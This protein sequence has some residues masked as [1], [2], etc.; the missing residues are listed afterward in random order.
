MTF[1]LNRVFAGLPIHPRAMRI[2]HLYFVLALAVFSVFV[3]VVPLPPLDFWWHLRVGRL[4]YET[5]HIPQSNLFAWSVPA[6][7]P[8][9]YAAWLGEWLFFR[10]YQVGGLELIIF[11]RNLLLLASFVVVGV[12]AHDRTGSWRL[13]ATAVAL[14]EAMTMN[15]VIVRTQNW[16]WLPFAVFLLTLERWSTGIWGRKALWLLPGIMIFWVNVHGAFVL[17]LVIVGVYLGA[18]LIDR[19]RIQPTESQRHDVLYL[20]YVSLATL[21][22]TF[23]NPWGV[24]IIAYVR[25]LLGNQAVQKLVVEWQPPTP[26]GVSNSI[27]FVSILALVLA[28]ANRR[29]NIATADQLLV[30]VFLW[31][32]WSGVRNVMWYGMVVMPIMLACWGKRSSQQ[33]R[34]NVPA[35]APFNLLL[36]AAICIPVLLIQPWFARGLSL[37][38]SYNELVLPRPAGPYVS[39]QTPDQAVVQWLRE[40]PGGRLFNEMGYGSFLIWALPD[41]QVFIDPRIELFPNAIWQD[42]VAIGKGYNTAALLDKYSIDRVLLDRA[43]QPQLAA[44]LAETDGWRRAFDNPWSEIWERLPRS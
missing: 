12:I 7:A 30:V 32:A 15:N 16:S 31:L 24:G 5:G 1:M 8:Y 44:I 34:T 2:D 33:R 26:H 41:T 11:V 40:H 4:I 23:I 6:D 13:A 36:A 42:Y 38:K 39:V 9:I 3:G 28:L 17:G 14:A 19:F 37:G 10:L 22:A 18:Q 29:R 35:G 27:F 43:S 20:T 21:A 25:S